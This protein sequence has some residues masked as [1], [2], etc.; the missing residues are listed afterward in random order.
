MGAFRITDC[1][2]ASTGDSGELRLQKTSRPALAGGRPPPQLQH[3]DTN[4]P[5]FVEGHGLP[6]CRSTPRTRPISAE[7]VG[8]FQRASVSWIATARYLLRGIEHAKRATTGVAVDAPDRV[9]VE[10]TYTHEV[11]ETLDR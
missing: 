3:G 11:G 5:G 1:L 2:I 8:R 7:F 9:H 4:R 10:H 6:C